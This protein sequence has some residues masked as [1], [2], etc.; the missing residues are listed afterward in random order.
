MSR[1][2][3]I[4]FENEEEAGQVRE[5]VRQLQ[6]QNLLS[7]DDSAVVVKDA[8]GKV[9][10]Q[11]QMDRG[12]KV[13]AIS[14]GLIGLLIGSIFFPLSGLIIGAV[15]GALVGKSTDLGVDQKFVK[16]VENAMHPGTSA[17][18]LRVRDADQNAAFAA[19]KPYKGTVYHSSLSTQGEETLRRVLKDRQS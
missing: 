18:F 11:N 2:I 17:I 10:V 13:G 12:V 3:V 7:L 15:G 9:S 5:T 8:N 16:D 4:T 6:K 19:L 1:L 14:G